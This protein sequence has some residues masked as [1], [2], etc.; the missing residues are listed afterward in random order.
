MLLRYPK[1]SC[2]VYIVGAILVWAEVIGRPLL[3]AWVNRLT[4]VNAA[5]MTL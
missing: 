2:V 5:A 4:L 1:L 3:G